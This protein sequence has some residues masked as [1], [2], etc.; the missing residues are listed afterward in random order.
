MSLPIPLSSAAVHFQNP[1]WPTLCTMEQIGRYTLSTDCLFCGNYYYTFNL[2]AFSYQRPRTSYQ[3]AANTKDKM[4][5][6]REYPN[7]HQC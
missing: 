1:F 5:I 6:S 7:I 4:H 3:K 2:A